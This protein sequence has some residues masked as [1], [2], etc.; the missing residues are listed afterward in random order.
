M[1]SSPFALAWPDCGTQARPLLTQLAVVNVVFAIV[2]SVRVIVGTA[3]QVTATRVESVVALVEGSGPKTNSASPA[4][5]GVRLSRSAGRN[6]NC[7][8]VCGVRFAL[9]IRAG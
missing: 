9:C 8:L 1:L 6:P 5:G 4:G 3:P 7:W 2:D